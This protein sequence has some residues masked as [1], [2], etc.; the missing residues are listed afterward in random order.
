MS[1]VRAYLIESQDAPKQKAATENACGGA[2]TVWKLECEVDDATGEALGYAMEHLFDAGALDA[3]F[4]PVFMKK[5]RPGWQIQVL[6]TE[7]KREA[8]ER[9]LF[10]DTTTIGIRRYPYQRTTL[11]RRIETIQAEI[12]PVSIK[13]VTMPDGT[14]RTYPEYDSVAALAKAQ[15][16]PF[17]MAWRL[18]LKSLDA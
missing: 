14:E 3:H 8:L 6:C 4:L 16:L 11:P 12:G 7:E 17:Q 15:G 9:I 2:G 13:I 5:E 18:V 1:T 10:E